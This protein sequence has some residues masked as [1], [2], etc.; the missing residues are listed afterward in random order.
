MNVEVLSPD[1][2]VPAAVAL[3]RVINVWRNPQHYAQ[4]VHL[5]DGTLWQVEDRT[6]HEMGGPADENLL[7]RVI[8]E[9]RAKY[10]GRRSPRFL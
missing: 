1:A 10:A 3:P 6:L 4:D 5:S 7:A 8:H 9:G 2:P